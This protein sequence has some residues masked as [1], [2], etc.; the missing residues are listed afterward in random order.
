M[1]QVKKGMAWLLI[2]GLPTIASAQVAQTDYE[3]A[4]FSQQAEVE[5]NATLFS[6]QAANNNGRTNP[7]GSIDNNNGSSSNGQGNQN[8]NGNGGN[9]NAFGW[10]TPGNG[11]NVPL[12]GGL[13]ILAAAAT[14][15]GFHRARRMAKEHSASGTE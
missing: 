15:L 2:I 9:G 8:G 11:T 4:G 7:P 1:I 5:D 12:D 3:S 14:G 6:V 13:S 10:A